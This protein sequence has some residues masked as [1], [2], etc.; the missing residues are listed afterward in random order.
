[1]TSLDLIIIAA[2][3]L[4]GGVLIVLL[5]LAAIAWLAWWL[6]KQVVGWPVILAAINAQRERGREQERPAS[7]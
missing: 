6:Y 5:L 1:M 7:R 4:L 2:V 3:K